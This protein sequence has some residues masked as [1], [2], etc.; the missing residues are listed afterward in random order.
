[1]A[2][3]PIAIDLFAGCGGMSLG[4]E[5]AG[6]D[7]A[8]AVEMD[9]VHAL[10]HH[11]NFNY[12]QTI[13][14]DIQHI[15]A[16]D[17][18]EA[19]SRG[20]FQ[21]DID[22]V[23]GGPPCQ[24]F[25]QIGKRQLEDPRNKLVFEYVRMIQSLSPKYFIFENVPGMMNGDHVNFL[26][27]LLEEFDKINYKIV[28]PIQILDASHFGVPQKRKRLFIIGFK[29]GIEPPCY[30]QIRHKNFHYEPQMSMFEANINT[31]Q[32][33]SVQEAIGD[34]EKINP[35]IE[36]D[37]G[38]ALELLTH[39]KYNSIIADKLQNIHQR[40]NKEKIYGHLASLHTSESQ[41]RFSQT[42]PGETE[43]IS[44][45]LKLS[46]QGLCNT[47]RAGTNRDRGAYTAPRPIHYTHPR[48]ITVREAARLH[49]YPDW[50]QFHRTIW[51]GFREIGNSVPPLLAYQVASSIFEKIKKNYDPKDIEIRKL[52]PVSDHLLSYNMSQ[53]A[54][55][56]DVSSCVIPKRIYK[57]SAA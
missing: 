19:L 11:Y 28:L 14:H 55:Y 25:S 8:V 32:M 1:M 27:E 13:C 22:L 12:T 42:L 4:L 54:K 51:H 30:P 18:E 56:W 53:A 44:R 21:G 7:V 31:L 24:G 45:F 20:G 39:Q 17:I 15:T 43:P 57:H 6:F 35:F 48:C 3:R 5:A 26:N 37:K 9:P 2:Q 33:V 10:V 29:K 49:S 38:I 40:K 50:F 34:L 23:A 41:E 36:E 52:E 47:L 16:E 46:P